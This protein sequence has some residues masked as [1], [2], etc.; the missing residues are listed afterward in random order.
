[1]N[2]EYELIKSHTVFKGHVITLK[3][4]ELRTP[5]GEIVEREIITHGGAVGIVPVTDDGKIVLVSQYRHA[6][7]KVTLEIPAGKLEPGEEPE[8]CAR[9]ELIEET[10]W[11]PGDL[12]KLSTFYTTPGYSNEIFYLFAAENLTEAH[13]K[14][15]EEEIEGTVTMGLEE[16]ISMIADGRIEDAKTVAGIGMIKIYLEAG[17]HGRGP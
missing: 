1:V 12:V 17:G 10:G 11:A 6:V 9:R 8:E 13:T 4:D 16:A 14:E 5:S 3:V 7:S 15:T 2:R